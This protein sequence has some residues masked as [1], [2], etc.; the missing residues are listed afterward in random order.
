MSDNEKVLSS[1]TRWGTYDNM[2]VSQSDFKDPL[3]VAMLQAA[4]GPHETKG[5]V[6][7]LSTKTFKGFVNA[8]FQVTCP[9]LKYVLMQCTH[10]DQY[11]ALSNFNQ[12]NLIKFSKFIFKEMRE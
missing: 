7:K 5:I 8:E 2:K 3:F 4:R 11:S 6:P 10:T 9:S 1:V 12:Q